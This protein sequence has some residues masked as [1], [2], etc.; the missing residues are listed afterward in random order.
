MGPNEPLAHRLA[1]TLTDAQA[2][3]IAVEC[4]NRGR[5]LTVGEGFRRT[6]VGAL[7]PEPEQDGATASLARVS[8][9]ATVKEVVLSREGYVEPDHGV[10]E[11]DC[12][13]SAH[14]RRALWPVMSRR[15]ALGLGALGL[16]TL[17]AFAGPLLPAAFATD[18]PS[19]DDVQR[20]KSNEAAKASEVTNIQGL[21]AGL[22][23]EVQRTKA[24]A[25]VASDAF[26]TAQQEYFDA[27]ARADQLQQQADQQAATAL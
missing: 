1:L 11:C 10:E 19:W 4:A 26:Y 21:I 8:D 6:I 18:Y 15:G 17:G 23:A 24:A 14:E 9:V 20:A 2:Y 22:E 7:R 27:A 5:A 12:A 25:Q 3:A 16:V 13:P